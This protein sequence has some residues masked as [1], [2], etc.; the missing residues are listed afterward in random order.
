M[1]LRRS[2]ATWMLLAGALA[3]SAGSTARA[4]DS[5]TP[6]PGPSN[7]AGTTAPNPG[8]ADQP[9]T[10]ESNP[11]T[12]PPDSETAEGS[13]EEAADAT[14]SE[15]AS[16]WSATVE[17]VNG[18]SGDPVEQTGVLL[19]AAPPPR[20]MRRQRP[21][22]VE[23]WESVTDEKGVANF[24][25]LSAK[26]LEKNLQLYAVA[27]SSGVE[28]ESSRTPLAEGAE[29][30]IRVYPRASN[31]DDVVVERLRT[32][33]QPWEDFLV[34]SQRW[35]LS[36][37]GDRAVDT[38][39]L[40]GEKF[41]KGLPLELPVE[42]EGI[43]MFGPGESEVVDS[44]AYWRGVLRPGDTVSVRV[45]FS[46]SA[47]SPM[48]VYRQSVDYPVDQTEVVLP[49]QTDH[50]KVGRL[51]NATL[52]AKGFSKVEATR[53]VPGLRPDNEYIY[54]SGRT[55]DPGESFAVRMT[56]LP[57]ERPIA[58][59]VALALG[60]VGAG[61]ILAF[62]RRGLARLREDDETAET[63]V[64][65]LE[66]EREE[67]LDELAELER[68]FE[69]GD[70]AEITY[71]TESLRLRERLSLIMEKLDELRDSE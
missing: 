29:L 18:V 35:N 17:V 23:T 52:A 3:I 33:F 51:E 1:M 55:L 53:R 36:V 2:Y 31:A 42:A 34:V 50:E 6:T 60:V 59:W 48:Q 69:A 67:L 20:R 70:V 21:E 62:A 56:G 7:P 15:G 58:P 32:V 63:A 14:D 40:P 39:A 19:K 28:F 24:S 66:R 57:F 47:S 61:F 9:P 54:A 13:G 45:R 46:I 26:Y 25:E 49:L 37:R 27:S 5:D 44:T 8:S 16:P 22:P 71:E 38:A 41:E 10:T 30:K 64:E 12:R 68:S 43:K 4:Q 65:V 11:E